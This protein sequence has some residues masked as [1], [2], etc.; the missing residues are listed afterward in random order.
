MS[1]GRPRSVAFNVL[2]TLVKV[3]QSVVLPNSIAHPADRR[4]TQQAKV[5]ETPGLLRSGWGTRW[6]GSGG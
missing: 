2:L 6:D 3:V 4:V 5:G 1:G